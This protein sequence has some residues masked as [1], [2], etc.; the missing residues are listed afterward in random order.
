MRSVGLGSAV[1]AIALLLLCAAAPASSDRDS[2]APEPAPPAA[3]STPSRSIGTSAAPV[4]SRP[5]KRSAAP[6]AT[7]GDLPES[8][9]DLTKPLSPEQ[10]D[11]LIEVA[12]AIAPEWAQW[13]RDHRE[14]DPATLNRAISNHG[15]RLV[16]LAVLRE[17]S[18]DLYALKID[19]LRIQREVGDAGRRYRAAVAAGD[20][21]GAALLLD[22]LRLKVTQQVDK[23]LKA[24]AAEL[25]ALDQQLRTLQK[26]V[27]EEQRQLTVESRNRAARIAELV[28]VLAAVQGERVAPPPA[29]ESSEPST[30]PIP[31][32]GGAPNPARPGDAD[33]S[34]SVA[35]PSGRF[36]AVDP[37]RAP[38]RP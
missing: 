3:R 22:E 21:A 35:S 31:A 25:V 5:V 23:E 10:V 19:E 12:E 33:G 14:S 9:V 24:R 37:G 32:E 11:S 30:R 7:N 29:P 1:T 13:L 27:E 38:D 18:P 17:Q 16:A 2:S 4:P 26:Q 6:R 34:S 20:D 15:R 36:D 8:D 28:N